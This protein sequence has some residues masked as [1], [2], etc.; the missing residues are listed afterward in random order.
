[1]KRIA[2]VSAV[3]GTTYDTEEVTHYEIHVVPEGEPQGIG[4]PENLCA[5]FPVSRSARNEAMLSDA[6]IH[7]LAMLQNSGCE[8]RFFF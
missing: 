4:D 3:Y 7:T 1:M 8:I 2:Y 6:I 5:R